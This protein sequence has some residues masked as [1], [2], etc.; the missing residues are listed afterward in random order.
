MHVAGS[1]S[2]EALRAWAISQVE[3]REEERLRIARGMH[4]E[5]GQLLTALKLELAS[6]ALAAKEPAQ[7]AGG[8]H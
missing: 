2:P 6:L 1:L 5:L 4:D 8:Q 3:A 7:A